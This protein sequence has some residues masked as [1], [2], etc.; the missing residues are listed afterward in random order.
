MGRYV[1]SLVR[2][3]PDPRTGE[4]V[5][6]G[7]IAGDAST[8]DWSIRQ[9]ENERRVRKLAGANELGIVHSFMARVGENLDAQNELWDSDGGSSEA[10]TEDWL[11][12]LHRDLRNVVQLSDPLP[13]V[14]ETAESALDVV[15]SSMIID[16]VTEGRAF[17]S[18]QKLFHGLLRAY[19][20]SLPRT[21]IKQHAD[22]FVGDHLH[23]KVDFAIGGKATYQL[24]QTWSFQVEEIGYA[25]TQVKAWGYALRNLREGEAARVVGADG[26]TSVV[27]G[28]KVDLQ[29]LVAPPKTPAQV[30][31]F[32]EAQGIFAALNGNVSV[33]DDV[34]GVAERARELASVN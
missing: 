33:L 25:S 13:I 20:Q 2:C 24:A 3:V 9:I 34:G 28:S 10:L 21:L 32:E 29:I 19:D 14:S 26:R 11:R 8:G 1:Y 23:T 12:G 15:F 22:L 17:V 7:A 5:T 16:P 6:V 30:D 18:R 4:F 31:V 27:D